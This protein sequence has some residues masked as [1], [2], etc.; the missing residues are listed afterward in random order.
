MPEKMNINFGNKVVQ[1]ITLSLLALTWGS[2]FILMKKGLLFFSP[3]E[4]AGFRIAAAMTV[5]LPFSLP[6]LKVLKGNFLPLLASG[7]FGNGIPAF[8]FAIAQTEIPS[9]LSG[10]L[11]SLTSLFTL[12]IGIFLFRAAAVRFQIIGVL[13]AL[14]GALGLIGFSNLLEF[15]VYGQYATLVVIAA[16]CYGVAVNIIKYY[17][18]DVRPTHIT[19]LSFLLTGPWVLIYLL[20][21]TP[22]I[23]TIRSSPEAWEGVLYI[24]ILGVIG[25]A[26]AVV[27]FNRL[28][29]ETT[30]VFASSVTYLIPIVAVA[31]GLLDGE[32]ITLGQIGYMALI[33]TGIFLIN[34]GA[35]GRLFNRLFR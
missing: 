23:S 11:N 31:W 5:L 24:S 32:E 15:G 21:F 3:E 26:I 33:L 29:K 13:I 25:T 20:F 18:H 6:N 17:L 12:V 7:L 16:G 9:S 35:P 19:S 14:V 4:V 8:L 2:S 1:W 30:A 22:F 10:I 34:S 27:I 28:I